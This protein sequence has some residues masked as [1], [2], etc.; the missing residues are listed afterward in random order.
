[1]EKLK[2]MGVIPARGGSKGLRRKNVKLLGDKPLIAHTIE[3]ARKSNYLDRVIVTTDDEEIREV[4]LAYGAESPFM[5]P[6]ELAQDE[7]LTVDALIHCVEYMRKQENYQPDYICLLQCTVPLRNSEDID[8]CIEKCISSTYDACLT[9]CEAE[10]N[11]YWM[12]VLDKE[13]LNPLM[14]QQG[15]ILRRQELPVVYQLNGA[16]YVIK[17]EELLRS[18]SVHIENTTGYVMPVE[19]SID[20]DSE[21]DFIIAESIMKYNE[22]KAGEED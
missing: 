1:M 10:S 13:K 22:M 6:R 2:V 9:I 11:P 19:R 18:K 20:I 4:G 21:L 17:T 16:V 12:K 5:R 8:G 3:A 14:K 7:S 15:T